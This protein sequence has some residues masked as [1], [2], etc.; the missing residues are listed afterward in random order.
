MAD[1][2]H[3]KEEICNCGTFD[4]AIEAAKN[5]VREAYLDPGDDQM[6]LMF[7]MMVT[8]AIGAICLRGLHIQLREIV[9]QRGDDKTED[10]TREVIMKA[11]QSLQ[12]HLGDHMIARGLEL[13]NYIK[14][15]LDKKGHNPF[16]IVDEE[17][18]VH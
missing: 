11:T 10:E 13:D 15:F 18:S 17:H 5:A 7:Q 12:R 2:K 9:K 4:D 8:Q 14:D 16:V 6:C 3:D 1:V